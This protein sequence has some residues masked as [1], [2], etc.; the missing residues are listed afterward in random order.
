MSDNNDILNSIRSS[1]QNALDIVE[2]KKN[3]EK[4]ILEIL[5]LI[6][7]PTES[8]VYAEIRPNKSSNELKT[9]SD[10]LSNSRYEKA[11]YLKSKANQKIDYL[12][13]LFSINKST[14]FPVVIQYKNEEFSCNTIEILKLTLKDILTTSETAMAMANLFNGKD[15]DY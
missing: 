5:D 7:E 2:I 3:I 13:C 11:I 14:G 4:E 1:F 9:I 8:V 12:L 6:K 10:I 15:A